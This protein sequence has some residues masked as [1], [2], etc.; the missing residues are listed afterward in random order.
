MAFEPF[1]AWFSS[2]Q[3]DILMVTENHA[4]HLHQVTHSILSLCKHDHADTLVFSSGM[5]ITMNVQSGSEQHQFW[6]LHQIL[7]Q[8]KYVR[9][10]NGDEMRCSLETVH[11]EILRSLEHVHQQ[12]IS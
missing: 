4:S 10:T 9:T 6:R 7:A 1:T 8:M 5:Q 11:H 3:Y 2:L 12:Y